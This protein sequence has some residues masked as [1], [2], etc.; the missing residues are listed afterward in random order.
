MT[1]HQRISR[2]VEDIRTNHSIISTE[3]LIALLSQSK[4]IYNNKIVLDSLIMALRTIMAKDL[5]LRNTLT[6]RE[7]EVVKL[8]GTGLTNKEIAHSLSLSPTTIETHRKNIRKKLQLKGND[9]LFA[10]ALIFQ[11][12]QS[13]RTAL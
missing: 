4:R 1:K 12:Q 13:N 7:R 9:N 2:F 8:I 6:D 11:I 3:E 10:F 5:K